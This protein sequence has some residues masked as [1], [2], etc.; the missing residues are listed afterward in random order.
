VPGAWGEA[1]VCGVP[2]TGGFGQ[3]AATPLAPGG[4]LTYAC[5]S[6]TLPHYCHSQVQITDFKERRG[7]KD[8]IEV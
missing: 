8:Y 3:P 1:L 6:H 2:L 7:A 4:L 5:H